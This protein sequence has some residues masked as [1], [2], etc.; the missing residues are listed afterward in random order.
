MYLKKNNNY[1]VIRSKEWIPNLRILGFILLIFSF[2]GIL[3]KSLEAIIF[4]LPGLFLISYSSGVLIDFSN[5]R[6][7]KFWSV[8]GIRFGDWQY[9]S[10]PVRLKIQKKR[11]S[12]ILGS[13]GRQMGQSENVWQLIMLTGHD[14]IL[15]YSGKK[16]QAEA[17]YALLNENLGT[18]N[19]D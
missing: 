10:M 16:E 9:L 4:F 8:M 12:Y 14:Q 3:Y 13:R 15:V 5:E 2:F 18:A 17:E 11:K 7:K 19:L 6:L 1:Y